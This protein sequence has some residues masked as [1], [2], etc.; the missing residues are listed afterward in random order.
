M[1]RH[2]VEHLQDQTGV[3]AAI[4]RL[5]YHEASRQIIGL[6]LV[7]VCAIFT[8]P[9]G[10]W[11]WVGLGIAIFGELFRW[12]AAGSIFKNKQL[13]T[14][15]AY[16]MVRH[17]LYVGNILILVGFAIAA[18]NLIVAA[19]IVVFFW[20]YYPTAIEYEDSKLERFFE[21][22]WRA[23]RAEVKALIPRFSKIN[24]LFKGEWS[25]HQSFIRNGELPI[26][27]YLIACGVL[28]WYNAQG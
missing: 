17:P 15:G 19:V 27:I 25:A 3:V 22:D 12:V 2:R 16:A 14:T 21:D 23:W 20:F 18:A 9:A 5:R 26:S 28:L 13:A 11:L 1:R 7:L 10:S 6:L 4:T 8:M 24:Q